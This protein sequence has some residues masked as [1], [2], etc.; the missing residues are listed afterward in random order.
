MSAL[1]EDALLF[2]TFIEYYQKDA[3]RYKAKLKTHH[4]T[5]LIDHLIQKLTIDIL[6]NIFL[7]HE[8][9]NIGGW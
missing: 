6:L 4:F 2:C 8:E 9:Q 3:G 1:E 7:N 5:L